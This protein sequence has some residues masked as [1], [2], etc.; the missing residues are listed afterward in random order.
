MRPGHL[1]KKPGRGQAVPKP[2]GQEGGRAPGQEAWPRE[3]LG[4]GILK[5]CAGGL[6]GPPP[7]GCPL[8]VLLEAEVAAGSECQAGAVGRRWDVRGHKP[9]LCGLPARRPSRVATARA[10]Q[11]SDVTQAPSGGSCAPWS[12]PRGPHPHPGL[13]RGRGGGSLAGGG[14]LRTGIHAEP[15]R[16]GP[17]APGGRCQRDGSGQGFGR[18]TCSDSQGWE[19]CGERPPA[20]EEGGRGCGFCPCEPKGRSR[21]SGGG[22]E[23]R[24]A[25]ARGWSRPGPAPTCP[26][27]AAGGGGEGSG[28]E[29]RGSH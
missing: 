28:R 11:R 4:L 17:T 15:H 20:Q 2:C 1:G 6:A 24:T 26:R 14:L 16:G 10:R 21:G 27:A 23:T 13:S 19:L 22:R 3:R 29:G 12:T 8:P 7:P 9:R 25:T 18:D 5:A